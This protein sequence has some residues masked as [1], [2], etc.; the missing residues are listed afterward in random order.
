VGVLGTV[1]IA[2]ACIGLFGASAQWVRERRREIGIRIAL[3]ATA[4]DIALLVT[5]E[6]LRPVRSGI[7]IGLTVAVLVRFTTPFLRS[8][9]AIG[10]AVLFVV[11][12]PVL[13]IISTALAC[14]LPVLIA[15]KIQPA[16]ALRDE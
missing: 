7:V 8:G 5:T 3:G 16:T 4:R 10:D 6:G 11:A 1:A 12:V 13:L 9:S 2:V 14:L 15:T